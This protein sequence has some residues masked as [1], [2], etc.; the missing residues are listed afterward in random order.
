[1]SVSYDLAYLS[2]ILAARLHAN[3]ML[4][5][6]ALR[7]DFSGIFL[8]TSTKFVGN[9]DDSE[10]GGPTRSS[11]ATINN[12]AVMFDKCE[13]TCAQKKMLSSGDASV[14]GFPPGNATIAEC[15]IQAGDEEMGLLGFFN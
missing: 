3:C 15:S 12:C 8:C 4:L 7:H 6:I 9:V 2:L 14:G 13:F 1:M 10:I 11:H 5:S